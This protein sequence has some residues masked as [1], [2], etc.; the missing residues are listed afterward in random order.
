[1]PLAPGA[2]VVSE[3]GRVIGFVVAEHLSERTRAMLRAADV[4]YADA[5]GNVYLTLEHPSVYVLEEKPLPTR[6]LSRQEKR[7]FKATGGRM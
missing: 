4:G 5:D 7:L 6:R 3:G 2:G 1:M